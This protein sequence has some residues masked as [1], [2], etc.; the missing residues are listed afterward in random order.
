MVWREWNSRW[1]SPWISRLSSFDRHKHDLG[2]AFAGYVDR[3]RDQ[4]WN[5]PLRVATQMYVEANGPIT[6]DT[7]LLL[8]QALL[9]LIGWVRFVEELQ[10]RTAADFKDVRASERLRELLVWIDVDP[11]IPTSLAALD[12]EAMRRK[13]PWADGPHAITEM[14]N[15]LVHPPRR[16]RLTATPVHARI[17]LQE[18]ALWYAELALLRLI[19]YRGEYANRLGAKA[20]GMVENVP[21]M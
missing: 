11:A 8:G 18:L 5:E 14:R 20:T 13:P 21:W 10:T 17:D 2:S 1:T 16:K 4:L 12:Q 19:D 3:W 6:A 15:S 9:E 7:S